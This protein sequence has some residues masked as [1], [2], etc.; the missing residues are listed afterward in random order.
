MPGLQATKEQLPLKI[1][2]AFSQGGVS[3]RDD[4][5]DLRLQNQRDA[6]SL[7][8]PGPFGQRIEGNVL[9]RT[10]VIELSRLGKR[11]NLFLKHRFEQ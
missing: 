8:K 6:P 11:D 10:C 9:L 1:S 3:K 5:Q 7:A 2:F 4:W